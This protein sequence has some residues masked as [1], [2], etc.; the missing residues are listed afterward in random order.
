MKKKP[1]KFFPE[2][3]GWVLGL[4]FPNLSGQVLLLVVSSVA[5]L[6]H[7]RLQYVFFLS[8]FSRQYFVSAYIPFLMVSGSLK[9]SGLCGHLFILCF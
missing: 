1:K 4:R 6:G 9:Y 2:T 5:F 7:W 3:L 8:R